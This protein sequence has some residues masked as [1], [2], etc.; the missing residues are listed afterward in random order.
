MNSSA[1]FIVSAPLPPHV[2]GPQSLGETLPRNRS[3]DFCGQRSKCTCSVKILDT[4]CRSSIYENPLKLAIDNLKD[5]TQHISMTLCCWHPRL[6]NNPLQFTVGQQLPK[7][8]KVTG[9]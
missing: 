7:T 6:C 8:V 2:A 5:I 4:S 1:H 3:K 9:I